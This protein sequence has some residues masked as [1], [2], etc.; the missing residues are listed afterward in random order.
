MIGG[1]KG[2]QEHLVERILEQVNRP[3][4]KRTV[5]RKSSV[6]AFVGANRKRRKDGKAIVLF[7]LIAKTRSYVM[8]S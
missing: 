7:K 8:R 5:V 3:I 2:T 1:Q 4:D 6:S